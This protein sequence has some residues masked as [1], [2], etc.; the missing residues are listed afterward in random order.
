M[1]NEFGEG[2]KFFDNPSGK[3][4]FTSWG[5]PSWLSTASAALVSVIRPRAGVAT[6][7]AQALIQ[8]LC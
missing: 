4:L 8:L 2:D 5:V 7:I 3:P 6:T 1:T